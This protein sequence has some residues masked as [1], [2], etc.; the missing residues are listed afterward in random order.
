MSGKL[1]PRRPGLGGYQEDD[2]FSSTRGGY[3]TRLQTKNT[4]GPNGA[5]MLEGYRKDMVNGFE[6]EKPLYN[7]VSPQVRRPRGSD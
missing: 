7:P 5:V 1:L 3:D 2:P 4:Q 6:G